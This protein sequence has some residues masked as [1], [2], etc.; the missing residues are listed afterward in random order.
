M[1]QIKDK[2]KKNGL[3]YRL[4]ERSEGWAIYG[5]SHYP[6]SE[7]CSSWEVVKIYRREHTYTFSDGTLM[8]VGEFITGNNNFGLDGSISV[9]S[10]EKAKRYFDKIISENP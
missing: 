10:Y 4:K 1:K 7:R 3:Y 8:P 6:D 9:V 5:V 2:F